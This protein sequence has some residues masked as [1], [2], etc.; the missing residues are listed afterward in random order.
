MVTN[1]KEPRP[2]LLAASPEGEVSSWALVPPS[3][4]LS[5]TVEVLLAVDRTVYVIDATEA[6]DRLLESGPFKHVSASPSGQ[7]VALYT[8]DGKVWIVSS[9]FQ[10]KYSEYDAKART[11]PVAMEWCGEDAVVLAWEDEVHLVG[12]N[13]AASK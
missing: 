4:T 1:Y 2:R 13:G 11:P 12:N 6:E 10:N 7:A 9:D 3:Y 5:R 8:S